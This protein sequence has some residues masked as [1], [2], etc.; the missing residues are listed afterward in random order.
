[1]ANGN[2]TSSSE[3][4]AQIGQ[5]L[6]QKDSVEARFA[7][8]QLMQEIYRAGYKAAIQEY[9]VWKNGEQVVGVMQRPI[10]IVFAEIDEMEPDL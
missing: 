3:L 4:V 2:A 1:M 10:K 8:K 5:L 6:E 9:A 7:A